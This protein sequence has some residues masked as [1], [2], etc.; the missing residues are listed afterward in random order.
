MLAW[1]QQ[2][3]KKTRAST[4]D[5]LLLWSGVDVSP[6]PNVWGALEKAEE[7][8]ILSRIYEDKDLMVLFKKYAEG[9]NKAMIVAVRSKQYDD[10]QRYAGQFYCYNSLLLRARRA[11]LRTK[12]G[13]KDQ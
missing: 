6:E 8:N 3:Q 1:F 7:D 5:Q 10:A 12:H 13:G 9:A 11:S 4:L 2:F